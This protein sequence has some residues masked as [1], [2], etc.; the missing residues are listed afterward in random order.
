MVI[1]TPCVAAPSSRRGSGS[2]P[3]KPGL[4]LGVAS[5]R[6]RVR[7]PLMDAVFCLGV[8]SERSRVRF[9]LMPLFLFWGCVVFKGVSNVGVRDCNR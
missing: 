5:G 6:P 2:I 8:V 3:G 7:F 1:Q 4:C 9:P